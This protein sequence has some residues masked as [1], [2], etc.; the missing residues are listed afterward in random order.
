MHFVVQ[1]AP[2]RVIRWKAPQRVIRWKVPQGVIRWKVP[3]GV[4][5]GQCGWAQAPS[6]SLMRADLPLRWRR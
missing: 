4:V 1:D 6:F 2:Q 5:G 3:Q